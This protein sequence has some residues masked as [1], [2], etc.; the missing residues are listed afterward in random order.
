MWFFTGGCH[1]T[2][3]CDRFMSFC[4]QCPE[5]REY[6]VKLNTNR[7]L[8][9]KQRIIENKAVNVVCLSN[10]MKSLSEKSTILQGCDHYL[11]PNS[12]SFDVFN[13]GNT[14]E[15]RKKYK[16]PI[17]KTVMFFAAGTLNNYRKGFDLLIEALLSLEDT[18]QDLYLISAGHQSEDFGIKNHK[19]FGKVSDESIMADLYRMADVYILPSREDNL[20]NVM[21]ESLACGTPVISFA[22]GGMVDTLDS[23]NGVMAEEMS[24]KGLVEAI[25]T[26]ID[27]KDGFNRIEIYNEAKR[28]FHF[29]VQGLN[30]FNLYN[31]L[32]KH[33]PTD[34]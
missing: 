18:I 24:A 25:E 9:R 19:N 26:F 27:R 14:E 8:L 15:I 7:E 11:I 22:T 10:W 17:D 20:P 6:F 31:K 5:T 29:Q 2:D 28:K 33:A 34:I 23:T 13:P 30:T 4:K 16:V 12:V 21:L 1:Y 3:G 32:I